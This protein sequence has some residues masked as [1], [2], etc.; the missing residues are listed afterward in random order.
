MMSG[1]GI[2]PGSRRRCVPRLPWARALLVTPSESL[3]DRE[4]NSEL[5]RRGGGKHLHCSFSLT[6]LV[7]DLVGRDVRILMNDLLSSDA[8]CEIRITSESDSMY[9]VFA[10]SQF[11]VLTFRGCVACLSGLRTHDLCVSPFVLSKS[12][13]LDRNNVA[14]AIN[15][16][17]AV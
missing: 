4:H 11:L 3:S 12:F 14:G 15:Y 1:G 10:D 13:H 17:W 16:S 6:S 9:C 2:P 7:S 5:D 8:R